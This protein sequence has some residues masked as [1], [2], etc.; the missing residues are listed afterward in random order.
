MA[1]LN[2]GSKW[3]PFNQNIPA[4]SK[5]QDDREVKFVFSVVEA[6]SQN[7]DVKLLLVLQWDI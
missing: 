5:N 6:S 7:K 4:D 2:C 1:S 3:K